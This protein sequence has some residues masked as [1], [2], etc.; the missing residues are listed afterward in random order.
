MSTRRNG[1]TSPVPAS[2]ASRSTPP[3]T[4]PSPALP[5]QTRRSRLRASSPRRAT[6]VQPGSRSA[7]R[8]TAWRHRDR[9]SSYS[10]PR[11]GVSSAPEHRRARS[12]GR[13][14]LAERSHRPARPGQSCRRN[15]TARRTSHSL[16]AVRRDVRVR[17]R[18]L[19]QQCRDRP[20]G[21]ERRRRTKRRHLL[22]R[23]GRGS[24]LHPGAR[25]LAVTTRPRASRTEDRSSRR[26][27]PDRIQND[28]TGT[29]HGNGRRPRL[30]RHGSKCRC[31]LARHASLGWPR[32]RQA[33]P[34]GQLRAEHPRHDQRRPRRVARDQDTNHRLTRQSCSRAT[35][36][37]RMHGP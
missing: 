3:A 25:P 8:S 27:A 30:R 2:T 26:L 33:P 13:R 9:S 31:R 12:R 20:S 11:P 29:N 35:A 14:V 7:A 5:R 6:T 24:A 4:A 36:T 37:I 1:R 18:W 10:P 15:H 19:R 21:H 23:S 28:E 22:H 16:R 34:P 32:P 17:R